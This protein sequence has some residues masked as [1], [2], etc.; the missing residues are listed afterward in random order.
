MKRIKKVISF[1]T[2]L[3]FYVFLF[4]VTSYAGVNVED[5]K[6]F[7]GLKK[8]I[9]DIGKALIIIAPIAG[10]VITSYC[11]IRRG[12]ADEVDHKKWSN[13]ITTTIFSTIGAVVAG[14]L[15]SLVISYFQ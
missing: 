13:R 12:A 5:S 10:T 14:V 8:L 1:L 3:I 2:T 4:S 9:E 6:I 7:I 11:F 15:V